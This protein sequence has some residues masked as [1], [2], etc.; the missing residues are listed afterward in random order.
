MGCGKCWTVWMFYE[1]LMWFF[2][3]TLIICRDYLDGASTPPSKCSASQY[4]AMWTWMET[5]IQV[6]LDLRHLA[7]CTP[8]SAENVSE[9]T[10]SNLTTF[11]EK[12]LPDHSRWFFCDFHVK[13]VTFLATSSFWK[14]LR[15]VTHEGFIYVWLSEGHVKTAKRL[16]LY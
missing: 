1:W 13:H 15:C 3:L 10:R 16:M 11:S 12:R 8:M 4:P 9:L 14:L 6:W 5:D 7:S 2:S